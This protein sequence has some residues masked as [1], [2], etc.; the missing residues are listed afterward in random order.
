MEEK[1]AWQSA[2]M[3]LIQKG[4]YKRALMLMAAN[5]GDNGDIETMV[6]NFVANADPT[7][8]WREILP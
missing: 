7:E 4:W 1:K 5:V 2:I 3:E 8:N 6:D